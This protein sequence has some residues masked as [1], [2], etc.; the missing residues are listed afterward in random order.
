MGR[1]EGKL[2]QL[3]V[4]AGQRF[5]QPFPLRLRRLAR[6]NIADITGKNPLALDDRLADGEFRRK[7]RSIASPRRHL[8]HMADHL[9]NTRLP[10]VTEIDVMGSRPTYTHQRIDVPANQLAW[11]VLEHPLDRGIF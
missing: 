4:G 1:H 8:T 11:P 9:A 3:A 10:V 6:R 7:Q 2:V 5:D